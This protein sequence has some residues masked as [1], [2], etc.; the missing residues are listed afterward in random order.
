VYKGEHKMNLRILRLSECT[1]QQALKAWNDGF[2]GYYFN[3]HMTMDAF[4]HRLG[5][6]GLSP[7]LSVV[8][9]DGDLPVGCILSGV[10]EQ[11]G[12]KVSWNG[13]TG[14]AP[15]YRRKGVGRRLLE[16]SLQ[17]YKEAGV[18]LST[19]E[20]IAENEKAIALYESMGYEIVDRLVFV[21]TTS[22]LDESAFGAQGDDPYTYLS[23]SPAECAKLSFYSSSTSWQTQWQSLKDG[24]AVWLMEGEEALAYAIYRIVRNAEQEPTAIVLYQCKARQG[25][26]HQEQILR[27][28]LTQVYQPKLAVKRSTMNLPVSN[29]PVLNILQEAGFEKTVEQVYMIRNI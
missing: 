26:M 25:I 20:A 7:D 28:L 12:L 3:A 29:Q 23:V 14:V 21:Q 11:G 17:L 27:S 13:G 18:E 22:A 5:A 19:L 24:Y 10:R 1:F 2:I 8:A 16:A 4:I 9:F 15:D 6:E